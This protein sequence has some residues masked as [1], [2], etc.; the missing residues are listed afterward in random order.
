MARGETDV[1]EINGKMVQ[2]YT[3]PGQSYEIDETTCDA[4]QDQGY[5]RGCKRCT[6][7]KGG[8]NDPR[9]KKKREIPQSE[10]ANQNA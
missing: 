5:F 2:M 6:F 1:K 7:R 3:C 8:K 10:K 4:R 9:S